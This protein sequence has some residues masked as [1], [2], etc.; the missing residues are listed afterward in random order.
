[1]KKTFLSFFTFFLAINVAIGQ[2]QGVCGS[3]KGYLE[4]DKKKYPQFYNS[5]EEENKK[6]EKEYRNLI[7]RFSSNESSK[8]NSKKVIPV[9]VHIIH[10]L[11]QENV[12]DEDVYNAIETL[13][14]N[15]NGQGDNFE[16]RTPP[17]FA[18]LRG[19]AD[20]EFKLAQKDPEGNQTTGILRVQSPLTFEPEPRNRV[21][22]LSYWNSYEYFNIWVLRKFAP[23]SDGNTL[24]GYAQFPGDDMLTDGV[25]LIYSEFNDP[26]SATLTHEVGHWLGLCHPW[27]CGAGTCGDDNI[28]DTPPSRE[29]NFGVGFN[30]FPYHVGLQN[31]G[32]VADSMNWAGE[33]FMNYMDYTPDQ[34][35]TMFSKEQVGVMM[36]TLEGADA[37]DIGYREYL[38]SSENLENTGAFSAVSSEDLTWCQREVDFT[39]N[40][41]K[42][43][44]CEGEQ[45]WLKSNKSVFGTT[46]DSCSWTL[47]SA[48]VTISA[49]DLNDPGFLLF[50]Y[51][52][53]G[54]YDI[55]IYIEYNE[56]LTRRSSSPDAFTQGPVETHP[57]SIRQE[58]KQDIVQSFD[59]T[60]LINM[61]ASITD[62]FSIDSLGK[63][64]GLDGSTYYRGLMNDTSYVAYYNSEN[65]V[66][67]GT[68]KSYIEKED[69]IVVYSQMSNGIPDT[70]R[71]NDESDLGQDWIEY[72]N[73]DM[74]PE[75]VY[76]SITGEGGSAIDPVSNKWEWVNWTDETGVTQSSLMM[77]GINNFSLG[78]DDLISKSYNLSVLDTPAI[79]FN[80]AGAAFD[81]FPV[82]ELN[83][84]YSNDCGEIWRSLTSLTPAEVASSGYIPDIFYPSVDDWADTIIAK[85]VLKDDNI[86]FKFEYVT[87]SYFTNRLYIDNIE[88]G[89]KSSLMAN[90]HKDVLNA[91]LSVYPNPYDSDFGL[92][93]KLENLKDQKVKVQLINILGKEMNVLYEGQILSDVHRINNLSLL[94][95]PKGIY[96]INVITDNKTILTDKLFVSN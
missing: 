70:Y 77:N 45:T 37:G 18:A 36:E 33:M 66:T 5:L 63:Y 11:G 76:W 91:R 51:D 49:G 68:C 73:S 67:G 29:A 10:D 1:M 58:I 40:T 35:T 23:Q 80:W 92:S 25:V 6:I 28:F 21:K 44:V 17:V 89:E 53:T 65:H 39:E 47:G 84:Y 41:G 59:I 27:D 7:S 48:N 72:S 86:R 95:L 94:E 13:N 3:Y 61:G 24:L 38:W 55:S 87:N 4:D 9:V 19:V 12:S 54:S 42:F 81:E 50:E 31:Q 2:N 60:D 43:S 57:D 14:K 30:N 96:F 71:F 8:S 20:V 32:C 85:N 56:Q 79:K 75:A 88:I 52:N 62:T 74:S 26:T 90:Q 34:Y 22:T 46:I 15:I 64:W 16:A 93:L 83:I 78:T 82:N 69:F